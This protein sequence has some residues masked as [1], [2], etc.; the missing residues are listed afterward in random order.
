VLVNA[1]LNY[2]LVHTALT[3]RGLALGTSIAALFNA[4]T[5][6]H[7]LRAH[8]HGLNEARLLG[9]IARITAA[10]AL[11]GVTAHY[12][13]EML[14]V[15]QPSHALPTQI[16][17]LGVAIG[18]AIVVLAASAWVLRIREFNEGIAMVTRRLRRS[19]R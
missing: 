19:R 2:T 9:A 10:S 18:L 17:R 4:T 11:M 15:W 3:Y 14:T 16:T 13:N 1:A 8:L 6:L 12:T 5:L 7:L